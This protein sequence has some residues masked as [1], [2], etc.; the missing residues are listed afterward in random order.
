MLFSI[1]RCQI[2][3]LLQF[4]T[5]EPFLQE[6]R[7]AELKVKCAPLKSGQQGTGVVLIKRKRENLKTRHSLAA[8][9]VEL[10]PDT[11]GC[12]FF[13]SVGL[14]GDRSPLPALCRERRKPAG[15]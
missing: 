4:F 9:R 3:S 1:R 13:T 14:V 5:H 15:Q 6:L 12:L 7:S 11:T 8:V 10:E 2:H